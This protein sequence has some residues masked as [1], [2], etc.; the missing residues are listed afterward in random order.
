MWP[1][2]RR[3]RIVQSYSPRGTNM[4]PYLIRGSFIGRDPHESAPSPIA[5][6]IGSSVSAGS[7]VCPAYKHKQRRQFPDSTTFEVCWVEPISELDQD[8][9]VKSSPAGDFPVYNAY[10]IISGRRSVPDR[11]KRYPDS[12]AGFCVR[13]G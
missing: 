3:T 7:P 12:A 11:L 9:K 4:H 5:I 6:S 10:K 13:R 2:C 8:V 1:H